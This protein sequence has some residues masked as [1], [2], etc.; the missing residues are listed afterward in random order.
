LAVLPRREPHA[1]ELPSYNRLV[2]KYDAWEAFFENLQGDRHEIPLE[3]LET[4]V[5]GHLPPS[6]HRQ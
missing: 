5:D 3:V 2:G 6:A 4:Y 1:T